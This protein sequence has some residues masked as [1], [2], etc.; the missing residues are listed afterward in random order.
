MPLLL[1]GKEKDYQWI[2]FA[3]DG[4]SLV[5]AGGG[6]KY[7]VHTIAV[8]DSATG[9]RLREFEV[10]DIIAIH[11]V[12]DMA[13]K[14]GWIKLCDAATG[15]ELSHLTSPRTIHRSALSFSA[16]GKLLIAAGSV[17]VCRW[18]VATGEEITKI[19]VNFSVAGHPAISSDGKLAVGVDRNASVV[20][21]DLDKGNQILAIPKDEYCFYATAFSPDRRYLAVA[22]IYGHVPKDKDKLAIDLVEL[23]TGK[24]VWTRRAREILECRPW[25]FPPTAHVGH[26]FAR[27][28]HTYLGPGQ[29]FTAKLT[30]AEIKTC[31]ESLVDADAAKAYGALLALTADPPRALPLLKQQLKPPAPVNAER[32]K[33]LF[34]QLGDDQ[35]K[36][37]EQALA[38]LRQAGDQVLPLLEKSLTANPPL[39]VRQRLEGLRV[40]FTALPIS[41]DRLRLLRAVEVLERIGNAEARQVLQSLAD[42]PTDALETVQAQAALKRIGY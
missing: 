19:A 5:S 23:A 17:A 2:A 16:D 20:V 10:G 1:Q 6:H 21:W 13:G 8:W 36:V 15:K 18:Q 7:S 39:E 41:G 9:K 29:L 22:G 42:G 30:A 24:T 4:K 35:Y 14:N 37:R 3:T 34:L 27:H 32:I 26:R 33:L 12:N 28:H 25:R 11:A 40:H 31:W 38:E